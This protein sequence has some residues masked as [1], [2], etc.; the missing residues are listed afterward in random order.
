MNMYLLRSD[1]GRL[2]EVIVDLDKIF[3]IKFYFHESDGYIISMDY[4]NKDT[5][6]VGFKN[7]SDARAELSKILHAMGARD[8][9]ANVQFIKCCD[10]QTPQEFLTRLKDVIEASAVPN[11]VKH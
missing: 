5:A 9:S 8:Y 10:Q 3:T 11:E 6:G 7:E 2:G 1:T 4:T